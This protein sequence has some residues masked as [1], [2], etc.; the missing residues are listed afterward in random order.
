MDKFEIRVNPSGAENGNAW[1]KI[2][3]DA[4]THNEWRSPSK[5][6]YECWLKGI[7]V[8]EHYFLY[9]KENGNLVGCISAALVESGNLAHI[10][11]FFFQPQYRGNGL[12][13][14]FFELTIAK[15]KFRE[16]KNWALISDLTMCIL[17]AF[18]EIGENKCQEKSSRTKSSLTIR[19]II[20]GILINNTVIA[21]FLMDKFEI[22][23]NPSATENGNAW[24]KICQDAFTHNEWR[25]P[26]K[27]DYE[28]W[29]KG[30]PVFE[31][32]FLYEKENGNLVGCISAA[33]VESGN[34][35][36]I[37]WFFFQ[38]QYRGNGLGTEFFELTIAKEKFREAK[39]WAL[40]SDTERIDYYVNRHGFKNAAW[41]Y[42]QVQIPTKEIQRDTLKKLAETY[43]FT[44]TNLVSPKLLENWQH[45]FD[46]D[47]KFFGG[48]KRDKYVKT[49]LE[50]PESHSKI[51]FDK[52]KG[53]VIGI[54]CIRETSTGNLVIGPLYA[55]SPDI[56]ERIL[57]DL[58]LTL[59]WDLNNY[60]IIMATSI[61]DNTSL[62]DIAHK[63]FGG[64]VK[65]NPDSGQAL[66][67]NEVIEVPT[68]DV[69]G[70]Y[71]SGLYVV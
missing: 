35:A 56:A 36:H 39:N 31:H 27:T 48:M 64:I 3:Q 22:L 50:H 29:L 67:T 52:A 65:F 41:T 34:L 11:W 21:Y 10:G 71:T 5:T 28:C 17:C 70:I 40:I 8:F 30:I 44:G 19:R 51:A 61:S 20:Q 18:L 6:D 26:S 66:F 68:K 2:C 47:R 60:E 59:P 23:I 49:F 46:Y 45:V 57:V 33:L 37:G 43:A 62:R 24:M 1:M 15:E 16:A 42:S 4:F 69:Y 12:G 53:H 58:L 63:I 25:S 55:D 7:P 54:G 13:T 32:Y 9:E 38:P 14:E